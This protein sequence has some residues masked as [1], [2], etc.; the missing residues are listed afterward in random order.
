MLEL[1]YSGIQYVISIESTRSL[2]TYSYYLLEPK[3]AKLKA[4]PKGFEMLAGDTHRRNFSYPVPDIEKSAWT[5]DLQSQD[6]LREWALGFN[7]LNYGATP[8]AALARHEM[9]EKSFLDQ[10]CPQGVRLELMFPSCWDGKN[11]DGVNH[12]KKSHM[13]YPNLGN[14]GT[15]PEGFP[16]RM[17]SLFYET[18]WNT[19]EFKDEEGEF[20]FSN[21]DKTGMLIHC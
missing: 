18:I 17:V 15:C 12:D 1:G 6:F 11:L 3:D 21:G 13:A 9:P 8:E 14:A 20:V 7:C 19:Y 5:G 16:V 10:N 2:T 4:F